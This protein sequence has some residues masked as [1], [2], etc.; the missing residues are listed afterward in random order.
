MPQEN[1]TPNKEL[2]KMYQEIKDQIEQAR[3]QCQNIIILGGF[4]VKIGTRINGNK[5]TVTKMGRQIIK[6]VEKQDMVILNE[7]SEMYKRLWTREQGKEKSVIDYLITNK[8]NLQRIRKMIIDENKEFATYR[9][10]CQQDQ[11][12]KTYSDH[13][14]ILLEID[15][16]TKL[17]SSK[18][19]NV[20]TRKG[21]QE[22]NV[23]QQENVTK[24]MQNQNLQESYTKWTNAVEYAKQRVS[25]TKPGPNPRRDIKELMKMRKIMRKKLETTKDQTEKIHLKERIRIIREHTID[26][27]KESRSNKIKK[28]AEDI[29]ENVNNGRKI[30]EVKRRIAGKKEVKYPIKCENNKTI[31][32]QQKIIKEY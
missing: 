25:R 7:E 13:N 18:Q 24:I 12:I 21:Y 1:T 5:E 15:Y 9:T 11:V 6:L 20:I 10:E 16:I 27:K 31:Q 4:N 8:D 2:K 30:W 14:V 26:K 17:E 19:I 29:R 28:V 23:L 3:Q 22:Y 32:D